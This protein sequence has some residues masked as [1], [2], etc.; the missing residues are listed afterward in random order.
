MVRAD[1]Q[2]EPLE[3]GRAG[4]GPHARSDRGDGRRLGLALDPAAPNAAGRRRPDARRARARAD[5]RAQHRR[6]PAVPAL[7]DRRVAHRPHRF[8]KPLCASPGRGS[9]DRASARDAGASRLAASSCAWADRRGGLRLHSRLALGGAG[10]AGRLDPARP[11]RTAARHLA[12]AAAPAR[13]PPQAPA[14][15]GGG[16]GAARAWLVWSRVTARDGERFWPQSRQPP[17]PR[18]IASSAPTSGSRSSRGSSHA[19]TRSSPRSPSQWPGPGPHYLVAALAYAAISLFFTQY[20][21]HRI[22]WN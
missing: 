15:A 13:H 14:V 9:R 10:D 5:R 20:L 6:P 7:D 18:P 11:D 1:R 16:A 4:R 8:R 3:R 2:R 17:S 12:A 21:A 22:G 19:A